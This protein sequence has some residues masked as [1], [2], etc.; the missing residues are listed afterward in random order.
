VVNGGIVRA[1]FAGYRAV[2]L[3]IVILGLGLWAVSSLKNAL[4]YTAVV[5]RVERVEQVCRPAGVPVQESTSCATV[6]A[7]SSGKRLFRHTAVH[8][9]YKSP[10]DG[11]ERSGVVFP[12]GRKAVQADNLRPGDR[13]K[14]LA[15]DDKPDD[16]KAE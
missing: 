15:H 2:R 1:F 4:N 3:L 9:R 5:A 7:N 8:V 6:L 12:I 10:A 16:I 14:I 11:Q 13:W